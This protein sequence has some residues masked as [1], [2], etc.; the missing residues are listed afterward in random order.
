[1]TWKSNISLCVNAWLCQRIF[2][3]A[4]ASLIVLASRQA[5]GLTAGLQLGR[6][7]KRRS[8]EK[9]PATLSSRAK[10]SNLPFTSVD[11]QK[12]ACHNDFR[13]LTCKT[14]GPS[15]P[16]CGPSPFVRFAHWG[17][18]FFLDCAGASLIVLAS[19]Q[20]QG[21]T[22]GLHKRVKKIKHVGQVLHL[23]L[24]SHMLGINDLHIGGL[25]MSG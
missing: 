21:L 4:S 11:L 12:V 22:A 16:L 8:E 13:L 15:P 9:A 14:K 10:R 25:P 20:A 7:D 24:T 3:C 23:N 19:R 18:L 2:D 5:Q 17:G 6:D 1:M